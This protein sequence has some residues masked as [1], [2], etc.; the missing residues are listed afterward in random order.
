MLP[1]HTDSRISLPFAAHRLAS[2]EELLHRGC[3]LVEPR[4][5]LRK[6]LLRT[7]NSHWVGFLEI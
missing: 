1:L 6:T 4:C 7:F 3:R 5:E 2:P